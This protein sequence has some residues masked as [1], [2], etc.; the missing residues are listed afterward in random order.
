MTEDYSPRRELLNNFKP[1]VLDLGL[2]LGSYYLLR[3]GFGVDMVLSL[4]LSSIPPAVRTLYGWL[5]DRS[6][7]GL[8]GLMLAVNV[9]GIALSFVSGNPR[10]MVAKDS[11][12][13][14]VIAIVLIASAFSGKPLL[15]AG[16][17]PWLVKG[18]AA[19]ATALDRL[20]A[21]SDRFRRLQRRFTLIWGVALLAECVAQVIGA[22]TLPVA[23][24]V[25]LSNVLLIAALVLGCVIGG[26]AAAD[27]ME[28]MI[29]AELAPPTLIPQPA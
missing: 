23:T 14:G 13:N 7:N 24:M 1:L 11:G 22:F 10:I 4:A 19:R 29:D 8:A 25:W 5:R 21:A 9:V 2:P 27:P 26:A 6:L 3:D 28:K 17:R 18:N 20:A 12:T 15:S 16:V